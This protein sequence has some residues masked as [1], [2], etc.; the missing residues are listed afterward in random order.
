VRA[1]L[2]DEDLC[3]ADA[4]AAELRQAGVQV[5]LSS[6]Q[7][8]YFHGQLLR[9][10]APHVV[11]V[12]EKAILGAAAEFLE[13]LRQD[14]FLHHTQLMVVRFARLY[15]TKTGAAQVESL[16]PMLQPLAQAEISLLEKL[17]PTCEVEFGMDE[18]PAHLL[19]ELLA[20]RTVSS[21]IECTRRSE[22][23]RWTLGWDCA[24]PAELEKMDGTSTLSH[25][26]A[27]DWLFSDHEA[28][29]VVIQRPETEPLRGEPILNLLESRIAIVDSEMEGNAGEEG[30][31]EQ[32]S[33]ARMESL[34]DISM[35]DGDQEV[36]ETTA[37]A[38]TARPVALTTDEQQ[39][40][41]P[42]SGGATRVF[43][44]AALALVVGSLGAFAV[45]SKLLAASFRSSEP[46]ATQ[47]EELQE[48]DADAPGV[49]PSVL[50]Q[51][52]EPP[53][54]LSLADPL[55]YVPEAEQVT[56][57]QVVLEDFTPLEDQP[58]ESGLVYF[59][60]AQRFLVDGLSDK[61]F[62]K[63]CQSALLLPGGPGSLALAE[64]FLH[65][66]SY[67]E[68]S[69][70]L[71]LVEKQTGSQRE[72]QLL[73][74]DLASQRGNV[75]VS[76]GLYLA[77]L[78]IEPNAHQVLISVS[79]KYS[80]EADDAAQRQDWPRA[81][82]FAR[83]AL[84]L[85]PANLFAARRLAQVFEKRGEQELSLA[86]R[87]Y[88][89]QIQ[90]GRIL[91]PGQDVAPG[92]ASNP[93]KEQVSAVSSDGSDTKSASPAVNELAPAPGTV[94]PYADEPSPARSSTRAATAK[95]VEQRTAGSSVSMESEQ[96]PKPKPTDLASDL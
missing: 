60:Q 25:E 47:V 22:R 79:R 14:P 91:A 57:C 30:V 32:G 36:S 17:G 88:S 65:R 29:V 81:E 45:T 42:S 51:L 66:R 54:A 92:S 58:P 31:S 8:K 5:R 75:P 87:D 23:L 19:V 21:Q 10:F 49:R 85:N 12:D 6:C 34:Y 9:Q 1:V 62:F 71:S 13:R 93:T 40:E 61:A 80:R 44:A 56:T 82:Q 7:A 76:R 26:Q 3:R 67:S 20:T 46:L 37:P 43:A 77:A 89:D 38:S 74:A 4:L 83:R 94:D 18:V 64:H 69:S 35:N 63:L 55:Y 15:Q 16:L 90:E 52:S 78:D 73:R 86:W 2:L 59:R 84:T 24:C 72:T 70:Q 48:V 50:P 11:I 96:E 28:R 39:A 53:A 27:L 95:E 68:A 41:Q 33:R